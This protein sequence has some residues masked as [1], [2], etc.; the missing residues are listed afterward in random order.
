M[1][2]L[3]SIKIF[4]KEVLLIVL[5]LASLL[6]VSVTSYTALDR[7]RVSMHSMYSDYLLPA[8]WL[9][10]ERNQERAIEADLFDYMITTDESQNISLDADIE[11]RTKTVDANLS[12]F[13]KTKLDSLE[14]EAVKTLR[15]NIDN[16]NKALIPIRKLAGQNKNAEAYSLFN[17]SARKLGEDIHAELM[18]LAAYDS[19]IA[20]TVDKKNQVNFVSALTAFLA[21]L[22]GALVFV[23]LL[24]ILIA[25][26]IA[27]GMKAATIHAQTIAS[28]NLAM[29]VP[30]SF[31]V[32]GDEIGT[33]ACAFRDMQNKL[34]FTLRKIR[35]VADNVDQGSTQFSQI[36]QTM[37]QGATEQASSAEEVSSSIEEMASAIKQN[38]ENAST[39]ESLAVKTSRDATEGGS[40]VKIAVDA[41]KEIT[42][43][44]SVI[45][46]IA[47][48]T[49]LLALNAAIEAAR[50]GEA[51]KGFAV[52]ASEVRKLAERSQ[53]A[54]TEISEL[55]SGTMADADTASNTIQNV[56]TDIQKTTGLVQEI[57][58]ASRE[59]DVGIGQIGKAIVQLD[60]VIQQNA[61]TSEEL[62]SMAEELAGQASSLA[63][64]ISFFTLPA[65]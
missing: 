57:S 55:S 26:S 1:R 5:S 31:L 42:G 49:N 60:T 47:R 9:N 63:Q 21:I 23:S 28:G 17:S 7:S 3:A 2:G 24:G 4:G 52:V 25:R 62:A 50:A 11:S 56:S 38:A 27:G 36:A 32:R 10:D 40:A 20:E 48:Q 15:T 65:A 41:M 39:T 59:Q 44:I 43:K 19:Q 37:S 13:E 33:L 35:T 14:I 16:Y 18:S 54:A 64:S 51:G 53:T 34:V 6:A 30:N 61:S 58:S 22:V 45:E 8:L 12:S 29:A 46:E